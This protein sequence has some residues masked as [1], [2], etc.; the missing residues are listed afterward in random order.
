MAAWVMTGWKQSKLQILHYFGALLLSK[1]L[2]SCQFILAKVLYNYSRYDF[3]LFFKN[4]LKDLG[5]IKKGLNPIFLYF[6]P[7]S[8]DFLIDFLK[9]SFW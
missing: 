8:Q 1:R 6:A 4:I 7:L 2:F 9:D 3:D 5:P